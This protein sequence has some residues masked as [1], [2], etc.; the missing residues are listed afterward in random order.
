MKHYDVLVIGAGLAGIAA[1]I[2]SGSAGSTCAVVE[3]NG[4]P[5]GTITA[6]GIAVPGLCA[7]AGRKIIAGI[8]WEL[9]E[10]RLREC[11]TPEPDLT[12]WDPVF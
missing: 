3:K 4:M 12:Q 11:G 5:G 1:A 2:Q 10:K 8:G 9:V 7:V 6:A